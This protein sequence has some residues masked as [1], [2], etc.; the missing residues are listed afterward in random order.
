MSSVS[1][2]LARALAQRRAAVPRVG[3]DV[4]ATPHLDSFARARA[5]VAAL[6]VVTARISDAVGC[7]VLSPVPRNA[8][9]TSAAGKATREHVR[10]GES[11]E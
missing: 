8:R 9:Q 5:R 1:L 10:G 3:L 6:V 7:G 4:D 11:D 2:T